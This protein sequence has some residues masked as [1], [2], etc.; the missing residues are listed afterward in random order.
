M[1]KTESP[2]TYTH[3]NPQSPAH[4]SI[5]DVWEHNFVGEIRKIAELIQD[6]PVIA[7]VS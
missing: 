6:Y 3:S 5:I 4:N 1:S 2:N 7:F